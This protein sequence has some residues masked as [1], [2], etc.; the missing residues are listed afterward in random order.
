MAVE[1]SI[2]VADL[3]LDGI[4]PRHAEAASQRQAFAALTATGP[5]KLLALARHIAKNGLNPIDRFAVIRDEDGS[6]IAL[7]GN[8][9]V[10]ALKMLVNPDLASGSSI[11]TAIK[12]LAATSSVPHRVDCMVFATREEAQPWLE[13]RHTGQNS[14]AGVVPWNAEAT[15][16][17]HGRKGT[18]AAKALAFA[19]AVAKAYPSNL[20]LRTSLTKVRRDRLTTLGRL[21]SDPQFRSALGL[22]LEDQGLHS[23]FAAADLEA[24]I[25]RVVT[26][27]STHLSVS[28]LKSKKQRSD[29][30]NKM[31]SD[32]PDQKA[33]RSEA[34]A[35][36]AQK[37]P[38]KK[39]GRRP[40]PPAS[41]KNLFSDVQL[42][43]LDQ[44]VIDVL[45]E[46]QQLDV[47]RYP[48]A[49]AI[50]TR[51]VLE[52]A[53]ADVYTRK[54]LP[55]SDELRKRV[56]KCLN[57][58]DPSGK[59]GLYQGVRTGLNDGTSMF[60]VRTLHAWVHNRFFAPTASDTRL[61]ARNWSPFLAALDTLV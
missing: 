56:L 46:L 14:G 37:V 25:T 29:Y 41:A 18:Q 55:D 12:K 19:D 54:G 43:K 44:R 36:A 13:L 58:I 5:G 42:K 7:E 61:T 2:A 51:V 4:N 21:I 40:S 10:A 31:R 33:R 35:L 20:Q 3:K 34:M 28:A 53:M 49:A 11:E 59:N 9:R 30:I 45:W 52:L 1:E 8:R 38:T 57:L 32:L 16:R 48:N 17:F 22:K 50:L 27:L 39:R 6:P 23:Y 60:A 24:A 26:D 15:Q 47:D